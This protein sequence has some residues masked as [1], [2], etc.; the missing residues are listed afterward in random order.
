MSSFDIIKATFPAGTMI[1]AP[2]IRAAEIIEEL[3]V[4]RRGIYAGTIG[5][6]DFNGYVNTALCI[7]CIELDGDHYKIRASAGIVADSIPKHEWRETLAKMGATYWA[8]T[9]E[10]IPQ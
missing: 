6:I 5:L 9:G 10:E 4:T 8:I 1:G 7:R 2:K 3:E